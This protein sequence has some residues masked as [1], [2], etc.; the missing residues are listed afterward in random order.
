MNAARLE[1]GDERE[2]R[3]WAERESVEC[4]YFQADASDRETHAVARDAG[5][6]FVDV[7]I[8]FERE[9][10]AAAAG[11]P[12]SVRSSRPDD[13]ELLKAIARVS[14]RD[15]RFYFDPGFDPEA[16]DA[17]YETWIANSCAGFADEVLVA[18]LDDRPAGYA[19]C[20]RNEDGTGQIGLIAV[21]ERARG[22]GLGRALV[23]AHLDWCRDRDLARAIVVTQG[24]NVAAS[25]LYEGEG[26]RT[27]A[28]ELTYHWWP[29][30]E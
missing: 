30:V 1:R 6:R 15:A 11:E 7:R 23:R 24:R 10:E 19:T 29:L 8:T 18:D 28:V 27:R 3:A 16:C 9:L 20:S 17:L 4:L 2:L 22:R 26:Y 5:F 21:D 12:S 13:V 14:H 25:R